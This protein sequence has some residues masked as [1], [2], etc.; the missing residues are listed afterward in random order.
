MSLAILRSALLVSGADLA[1]TERI[2]ERIRARVAGTDICY[3]NTVLPHIIISAGVAS[4]PDSGR[5]PQDIIKAAD[6]ALYAA[7]DA[8]RNCVRSHT[9]D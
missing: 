8:G 5:W 6:G 4:F 7:K 1:A 2:A 9:A 3:G